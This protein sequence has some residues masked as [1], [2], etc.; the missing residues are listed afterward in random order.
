[1]IGPKWSLNKWEVLNAI[2]DRFVER[3][4]CKVKNTN[5]KYEQLILYTKF[6][7]C[8]I[9]CINTVFIF[10]GDYMKDIHIDEEYIKRIGYPY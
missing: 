1:M 9:I 5:R 6:S 7:V 2:D 3:D 4:T 8:A 10:I